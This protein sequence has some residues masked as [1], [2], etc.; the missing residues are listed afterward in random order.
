MSTG[1]P[2]P[3]NE[4]VVC[5]ACG[6]GLLPLTYALPEDDDLREGRRPHLQDIDLVARRLAATGTSV[7]LSR[8]TRE[9]L[10]VASAEPLRGDPKTASSRR[11]VELGSLAVDA[12]REH[13][14]DTAVISLEGRV[15][16]RP[17]GRTL[18]VQTVYDSWR[19]LL[20]R[21]GVPIVRP[22][23]ARHTTATLLLGQG[24]HPK[25]VSEMLDHT[26]VAITLDPYSH[27]TPAMHREAGRVLDTLL[28]SQ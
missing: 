11:V 14:R 24:V 17:D 18:A 9:L 20:E 21:A 16:T 25:L 1:A 28:R 26:T 19:R 13:R 15:F 12:L 5:T 2:T 7:R 4:A 8:R 23:D 27:A 3:W 22:H 10:G 6:T